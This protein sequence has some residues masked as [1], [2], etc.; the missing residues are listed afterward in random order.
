MSDHYEY[1]FE[2][3]SVLL[4]LMKPGLG[5]LV[6]VLPT[7]VSPNAV[8]LGGHLAA[9]T[10]LAVVFA[11][12]KIDARVFVFV[13]LANLVYVIADCVD[14]MLARHTKRASPLGELLD[15][16]LDAYSVP[17]VPLGVGFA[18]QQ[19]GWL[20]L[21]ATVAVSFTHFGT[22]LHGFRLGHVHLGAV[23]I[24][25]GAFVASAACIVAALIGVDPL[26]VPR[27]GGVS[28][29]NALL[30]SVVLGG[31]GA[32]GSMRGLV[33]YLGEVVPIVLLFALVLGWY[34]VGRLTLPGAGFLLL[35]LG[36]WQDGNTTGAR[37]LRTRLV[38]WD[39]IAIA[40]LVGALVLSVALDLDA[41]HQ[42]LA[43]TVVALYAL[44][45]GGA[46]FFAGVSALRGRA[47]KTSPPYPT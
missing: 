37:L 42:A 39:P 7:W 19:P 4:R 46:G 3:H 14:G 44:G 21:A 43:A 40:L 33:R 11:A 10:G 13:A 18:M 2:D 22:F 30:V 35:V 25:E 31:L 8:T 41:S 32:F 23:G 1:R 26:I 9:W 27:F 5:R 20:V 28:V 17:I 29:A 12:P 38:L 24:I 15:H 34:A 45:R 47:P 36:A 6:R 16:W